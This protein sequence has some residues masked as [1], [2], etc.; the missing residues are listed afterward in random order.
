[1]SDE[2]QVGV[3]FAMPEYAAPKAGH[4][5]CIP[6]GTMAKGGKETGGIFE[7]IKKSARAAPGPEYYNKAFLDTKFNARARNGTFSK[8]ARAYGKSK[9]K[10]PAVGQ[11]ETECTLVKDRTRGGIMSRKGRSCRFWDVAMRQSKVSQTPGRYEAGSQSAK[12][13]PKVRCP[14]FAATRTDSRTPR[15]TSAVAPGYYEVD[16]RPTEEKVPSYTT[17]REGANKATSRSFMD[18]VLKPHQDVPPPGHRG[19]PDSKMVDRQGPARHCTKLIADRPAP[20][21]RPASAR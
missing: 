19:V 15:K 20:D 3:G 16:K 4:P 21:H 13:D 1:M 8:L 2:Q 18:I 6:F 9:D 17:P 7:E 14:I 12:A 10:V 5:P 11:Y